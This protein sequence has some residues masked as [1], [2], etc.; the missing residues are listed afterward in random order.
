MNPPGA[1]STKSLNKTVIILAPMEGVIDAH[2][3]RL[4]TT[5][6]G[7]ERCVTEFV[8]ITDQLLPNRVYRRLCPELNHGGIIN[9]VPVYVQL[10]GADPELLAESGAQL[11]GLG[12]A[13]VDLN[14]GCPAKAVNRKNGGAVLLQYPEQVHRIIAQVRKAVPAST[15]VTA[16]LRLGY[17][18][19][20]L[21]LENAQ[22]AADAGASSITVHART[23]KDGYKP[24]AHWHWL[25]RIREHIDIDVI[26]NG[27]IWSPADARRCREVSGCT[28]IMLG[29][30]AVARPDLALAIQQDEAGKI[31]QP[32]SW[33]QVL[34]Q[35]VDLYRSMEHAGHVRAIAP[36][37]KQW[38]AALR[39]T[40]PEAIALF[41]Q[42]RTLRC[43]KSLWTLLEQ[44]RFSAASTH[45]TA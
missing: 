5:I 40:Y 16:K 31:D 13:G 3:R 26:A 39:R 10:L 45:A 36:R 41:D 17:Q 33:P 35:V 23:Q 4:L 20:S 25:A 14:F 30:G 34:E 32:L 28:A 44:H 6:G 42:I 43:P 22:A 29:R 11:A 38:L 15:P 21:A 19:T 8:R 27:E 37:I 18:D 12:A 24:P 1:C 7:Y 9:S 2:M